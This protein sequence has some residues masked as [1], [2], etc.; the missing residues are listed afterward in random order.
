MKVVRTMGAS[1][2]IAVL[3]V[4]FDTPPASAVGPDNRETCQILKFVKEERSF[5]FHSLLIR[6]RMQ[7][8]W[9]RNGQFIKRYGVT[10]RVEKFDQVTITVDRCQVQT[11]RFAWR[12]P[13]GGMFAQVTVNYSNCVLKYG[14]WQNAIMAIE[15]WFYADGMVSEG[16]RGGDGDV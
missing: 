7:V 15:R 6:V 12:N 10:C 11:N 8:S 4:M 2:L 1:A 9:C 14:C 3:L 16:P 13:V 5:L